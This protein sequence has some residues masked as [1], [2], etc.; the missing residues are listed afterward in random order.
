MPSWEPLLDGVRWKSPPLFNF[1]ASRTAMVQALGPPH[2]VDEDSNGIGLFDA[3]C[4]RFPCGLEVAI[5]IFKMRSDGSSVDDPNELSWI[6]I[7][8]NQR[9]EKHIRFHVPVPIDD[10]SYWVPSTLFEEPLGWR[11][12]RQD[13]HG[14]QF[15]VARYP[16]RCEADAV[17]TDFESRGHKQL[18]WVEECT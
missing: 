17:A 7:H 5:W 18:Y 4:L 14:N 9:H 12:M 8:A 11:V 10:V 2:V 1:R 6:E 16:S 13:D 15:E 3:W